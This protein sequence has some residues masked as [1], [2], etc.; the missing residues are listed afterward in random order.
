LFQVH[1]VAERGGISH[2][3]SDQALLER[4]VAQFVMRMNA[5]RRLESSTQERIRLFRVVTPA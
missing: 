3:L 2:G 1:H 4:E 5:A